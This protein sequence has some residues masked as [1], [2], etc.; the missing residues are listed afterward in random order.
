MADEPQ[1]LAAISGTLASTEATD[2]AAVTSAAFGVVVTT[3]A[4]DS[5][6][7][8][9][10]VGFAASGMVVTAEAPDSAAVVA[11]ASL[12]GVLAA[13]GQPDTAALSAPYSG[14]LGALDPTDI[15]VFAGT[16]MGLLA[17][18]PTDT[19]VFNARL[20]ALPVNLAGTITARSQ[21]SATPATVAAQPVLLS[22]TITARSGAS[23][24]PGFYGTTLAG[25]ITARSSLAG[26]AGPEQPI[27]VGT[28][29]ARARLTASAEIATPPPPYP[30]PFPTYTI[31]DYL[32]RIVSE[33]NQ[34]PRYM[35]TVGTSLEG[36]V[37]DQ[38]LVAGLSG[39]FDL[40]YCVGQQEDFTGQWIG[41]SRWI[42]IPAPFFSWDTQALGWNEANWKGPADSDS[43]LEKLDDYHYRL[44]LYANV[45]ANHWNGS[46]PAAYAAWD[47]LFQY[48]GI[49]VVIQDYGDMT[50][51]Y[52]FIST[53]SPDVVLL[54]LFTTG[55]MDLRPEGVELRAYALQA[56]PGAPF[57]SWDSASDSVHGWDTGSWAVMVPPGEIAYIPTEGAA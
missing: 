55:Q 48:T 53:T 10:N 12:S 2:S 28:I 52:G 16:S 20:S 54:S 42:E 34:K 1:P 40:D 11:L 41:K 29:T 4:I 30:S 3:E 56:Q 21:A 18:D 43:A 27:L 9:G 19:A 38:Q 22:G 32:A 8:V 33:H 24:A 46:I 14:A 49:K 50:M 6:G 44:L 13:T 31:A 35:A 36:L 57:F 25:T 17:T 23:L 37:D 5:A 15:A 7:L 26:I 39:L 45:I 47:T 51:L